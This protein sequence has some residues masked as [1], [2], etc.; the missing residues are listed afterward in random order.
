MPQAMNSW[1][2]RAQERSK[3]GRKPPKRSSQKI[4]IENGIYNN[5]L[6]R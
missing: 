4:L 1:L 5:N 2:E 3:A 6:F